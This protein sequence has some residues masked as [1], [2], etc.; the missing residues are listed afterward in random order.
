MLGLD[1]DPGSAVAANGGPPS[2]GSPAQMAA[3]ACLAHCKALIDAAGPASV[4]VKLQLACFESLGPQGWLAL[5][6]ASSY[7]HEAGLLVIADGKRGDVPHTATLYA[8]ALVGRAK[9]PWGEVE[10]L[11]ADAF[12]ANPLLGLDSLQAMVEVAEKWRAG[13]FILVRTTNAG[14]SKIQDLDNGGAPL[15]ERL[16]QAVDGLTGPLMGECGLSGAGAV[17]AATAP[18]H[19][20][21]L[22]QLMPSSIFLVPG[23][24]AQGGRVEEL[25]PALSGHPASV[26]VT[27]SR[28]I[29]SAYEKRGGDPLQAARAEAEELKAAVWR[30]SASG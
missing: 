23:V 17:V 1:P 7:A 8:Q 27:A 25:A 19:L 5:Q 22:R 20:S 2:E 16:A 3:S 12:T 28:S 15:H 24:G 29:A 4:A 30:L 21:R 11:A 26:L 13:I 14:A 9:T 10:A 18:E 6:S